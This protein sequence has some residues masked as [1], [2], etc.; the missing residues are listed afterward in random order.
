MRQL[1]MTQFFS[2]IS[3]I[4]FNINIIVEVKEEGEWSGEKRVAG[5]PSLLTH[6]LLP[7]LDHVTPKIINCSSYLLQSCFSS[8]LLIIIFDNVTVMT[9]IPWC[10]HVLVLI[11]KIT[12][13]SISSVLLQDT[14]MLYNSLK[15]SQKQFQL[16]S[17]CF[18]QAGF[19]ELLS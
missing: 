1:A 5:L 4:D 17:Q 2:L 6:F 18:W 7:I 10:R 19:E 3:R 12:C 14:A 11:R 15:I 9:M 13:P 16:S 8:L